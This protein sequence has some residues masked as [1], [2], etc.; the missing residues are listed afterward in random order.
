MCGFVEGA[1]V[2]QKRLTRTERSILTRLG[3]ELGENY[4]NEEIARP[5]RGTVPASDARVW[6]LARGVFHNLWCTRRTRFE[7][8]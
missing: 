1:T 2:G 6:H 5:K 8:I 7:R 3:Y 4:H